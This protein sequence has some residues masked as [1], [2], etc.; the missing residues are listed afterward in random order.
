M[1]L[2]KCEWAARVCRITDVHTNVTVVPEH[3][4][5]LTQSVICVSL[6]STTM[7][8]MLAI[9]CV[10]CQNPDYRQGFTDDN[11]AASNRLY[12]FLFTNVFMT[13]QRSALRP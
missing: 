7:K 3:T 10:S 11:P 1:F 12:M 4:H 2:L 5:I 13:A 9:G 8:V 6:P